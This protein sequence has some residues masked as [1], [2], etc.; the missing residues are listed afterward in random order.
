[1]CVETPLSSNS[2]Q[3]C[4]AQTLRIAFALRSR[5]EY[6]FGW[7][8]LAGGCSL[9]GR[10]TGPSVVQRCPQ[11]THCFRIEISNFS[12]MHHELS[13]RCEKAR[14]CM[15]SGAATW[16]LDDGCLKSLHTVLNIEHCAGIRHSAG[17][18][19][20]SA[21]SEIKPYGDGMGRRVIQPHP[22]PA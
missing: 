7:Y 20:P 10:K 15:Q 2:H 13:E 14:P 1:M 3:S 5:L 21:C 4:I 8:V 16:R 22:T 19:Q 17:D 9:L 6:A 18:W 12:A 11:E